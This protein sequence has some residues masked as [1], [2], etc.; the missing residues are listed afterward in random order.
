ML[1]DLDDPP[2]SRV[3]G[4]AL[5]ALLGLPIVAV[6]AAVGLP[7]LHAR[8]IGEARDFDARLDHEDTY[9]LGLCSEALV[10]ERDERLCGCVLAAGRPAMDCRTPF[11]E[12]SLGR[13]AERC[14]EPSLRTA[15]PGFCACVD[16]LQELVV[17]A[18][19]ETA[20]RRA[21]QRYPRCAELPDALYLP[22]LDELAP[23]P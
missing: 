16:T 19:D 21:V 8:V 17:G 9:L 20:A 12:W 5:G 10:V 23:T 11:L 7:A 2:P 14:V 1:A 6:L 4:L 15:A 3:R 22:T 13:Q 18:P